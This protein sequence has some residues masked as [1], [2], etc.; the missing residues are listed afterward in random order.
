[1][2]RKNRYNKKKRRKI[3]VMYEIVNRKNYRNKHG[4]F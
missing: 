3:E 1:M 4:D 2:I